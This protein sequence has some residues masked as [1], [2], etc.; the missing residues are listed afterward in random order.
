LR[1][2]VR[3]A[4]SDVA[5]DVSVVLRSQGLPER[6]EL[7]PQLRELLDSALEMCAALAEPRGLVD[8]ISRDDFG[9]VYAGEGRNSEETPLESI[10]PRAGALALFAAT[11]GEPVGRKIRELFD[12][13][14]LALAYL[15]DSVASE[16]ADG[17]STAL[18]KRF[19]AAL[20]EQGVASTELAVLP[21]SPGYCGWHVSGQGRLFERLRPEEIGIALNASFLMQPLK[22]VSG[23]LVAGAPEIH[24][25]SPEY[26]FCADCSTQACQA[27]M[28]VSARTS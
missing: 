18:A 13:N 20:A 16:T 26:S 25:F 1:Q 21:Y 15:L 14:D 11:L 9:G 24:S 19:A 22:S 5:P 8:G 3:F 17:L 7:R 2:V 23:V 12:Q 4:A 6:P 10:Y 27:R 28:A